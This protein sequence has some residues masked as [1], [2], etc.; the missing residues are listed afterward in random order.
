MPSESVV[1]T[2]CDRVSFS[3]E[4][5]VVSLE[6]LVLGATKLSAVLKNA[7]ILHGFAGGFVCAILGSHRQIAEVECYLE[8][9]EEPLR[10]ILEKEKE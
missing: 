9:Q 8:A 4:P 5:E 1:P 10:K 3:P 6:V 2:F 7:G